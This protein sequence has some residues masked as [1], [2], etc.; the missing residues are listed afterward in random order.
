[1]IVRGSQRCDVSAAHVGGGAQRAAAPR[2]SW[3][4]DAHDKNVGHQSRPAAISV[5]EWMNLDERV[6]KPRSD[7]VWTA[8]LVFD[9]KSRLL[10]RLIEARQDHGALNAEILV[11][12]AVRAGPAP[13]PSE[14][15][16]VKAASKG[17][18]DRIAA[19]REGPR[20]SFQMFA[21]SISF[22]S[23]RSVRCDGMRPS[24]SSGDNGVASSYSSRG[25]LTGRPRGAPDGGG[26][27]RRLSGEIP[28]A[29]LH[30]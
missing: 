24:R 6:M 4:T 19:A 8:R 28:H 16:A 1:M 14:H 27:A 7:L 18:I 3:P 13:N 17:F 5:W 11:R 23:R 2:E 10:E 30:R 29:G 26:A 15:A 9:P 21:R 20:V 22:N 12:S 25:P